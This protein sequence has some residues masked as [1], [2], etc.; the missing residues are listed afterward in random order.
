MSHSLHTQQFSPIAIIIIIIV[1]ILACFVYFMLNKRE[2]Q[3]NESDST[4][5]HSDTW[6][7][8]NANNI[9]NEL[10]HRQSYS[11]NNNLPSTGITL[12]RP[13]PNDRNIGNIDDNYQRHYGEVNQS[14]PLHTFPPHHHPILA[15]KYQQQPQQQHIHPLAVQNIYQQSKS[16][17]PPP[18]PIVYNSIE[19]SKQHT[20]DNGAVRVKPNGAEGAI[21]KES[22]TDGVK[23]SKPLVQLPSAVIH[24]Q[25]D[26]RN[27]L[28]DGNPSKA[29]P[30]EKLYPPPP[31][32]DNKP[33]QQQQQQQ[34]NGLHG[35]SLVYESKESSVIISEQVAY[36][37]K[38]Q[39]IATS[40]PNRN[41]P[42]GS[43]TLL[44]MNDIKMVQV[45]GGGAFGQVWKGVWQSTPVAVKVLSAMCQSQVPDS[46]LQAFTDEVQIIARLRHPNICLF[47]GACMDPPNRAIVTELVSRGSLWEA[48]RN[49]TLFQV[50]YTEVYSCVM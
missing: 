23:F 16:N 43:V 3:K 47:L 19:H 46:V 37:D 6:N 7:Y 25:S 4:E 42:T 22:L 41:F 38:T 12:P 9:T 8:S 1:L 20:E 11:T 39:T 18:N 28:P 32:P 29:I 33:Q 40:T 17:L 35:D 27:N 31:L 24:V 13:F 50:N 45:I 21:L 10:R 49:P 2:K 44:H 15:K 30:L 26:N 36:A 14:Q 34:A 5:Y 48:L